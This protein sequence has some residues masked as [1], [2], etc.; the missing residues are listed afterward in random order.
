[1]EIVRQVRD[2][3]HADPAKIHITGFSR[4]GFVTW[5]LLCDHA[6]IFASA[7][8]AAAGFSG[9]ERTC[10]TAGKFPT[11]EVPILFLMGRTDHQVTY[12]SMIGIRDAVVSQYE[13]G[14][15][16]ILDRDAAYTHSRWIGARGTSIETFEH[17]YETPKDGPWNFAL[18]HCIPGSRVDPHARQYALPCAP[19]NAFV[20]GEEVMRFFEAHTK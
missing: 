9:R 1:M 18:G 15:A 14:A 8:P 12:A 6:D 11:R 17:S 3:I 4:G 19:P 16:Q 10:F 2:A 7:A 13:A 20:W 5:R